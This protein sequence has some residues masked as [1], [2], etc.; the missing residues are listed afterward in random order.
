MT[1]PVVATGGAPGG[2]EPRL[3]ENAMRA[4]YPGNNRFVGPPYPEG[5]EAPK[6]RL[7]SG[8]N[9]VSGLVGPPWSQIVAYD[10]NTGAIKWRRPLGEDELAIAAGARDAGVV[11]GGESHGMVVTA[12]GLVFANAKDGKIRAFDADTGNVVWVYK[13]PAGSTGLLSMYQ[14]GGRQ[15][16]VVPSSP[17]PTFGLGRGGAGATDNETNQGYIAFALPR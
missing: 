14:A 12:N 1:G 15:F 17:G 9:L 11:T 10:L 16:L 3:N 6:E 5:V 4:Q 8:Y 7:Y 2:L 13:L